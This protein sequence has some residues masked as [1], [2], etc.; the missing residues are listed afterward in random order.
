MGVLKSLGN[1]LSGDRRKPEKN[2]QP[3][4]MET[5]EA[6]SATYSTRFR[7]RGGDLNQ[8]I[9]NSNE[10]T[11]AQQFYLDY[12]E[13]KL[14]EQWNLGRNLILAWMPTDTGIATLS[15]PN[16][17]IANRLPDAHAPEDNFTLRLLSTKKE[18][19]PEGMDEIAERLQHAPLDLEL[20]FKAG[21]NLPHLAIDALVARY[22]LTYVTDRAVALFDIVGFSLYSP[23]EQVTQL[24]SLS[25]SLN[26]AQARMLG[27]KID[28]SFA[29]ASTGDGFY[30]WNRDRSIQA[31][32]NLYHFMHLVL[33]DNAVARSKSRGNVTPRLRTSFHVGSHYEFYQAEGLNPTVYSYIV[34]DVTIELAR[35]IERAVPGQVVVGD[36]SAPMPDRDTGEVQ[37]VDAVQFI[38]KTQE[39]LS[40]LKG[41]VVSGDEIESISC[42]LTGERGRS[43]NYSIKK[44]LVTDKHGLTRHAFNAKINIFRKHAEPIFLGVQDSE[45]S[46]FGPVVMGS[47]LDDIGFE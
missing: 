21:K 22:S 19:T 44:Y 1:R 20:P 31:N 28:I 46:T 25:Y 40:G 14:R 5:P 2:G 45:L 26:S 16:Y 41:L 27:R 38:E 3:S 4:P 30:V 15:V 42:Y 7:S 12:L 33:A 6:P 34:G 36:F 13:G 37:R 39:T 47:D 17:L 8:W 32:I 24:N 43:G 11:S 35:L 23:L 9:A 18:V 29:R 10:L